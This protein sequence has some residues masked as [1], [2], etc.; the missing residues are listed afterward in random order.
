M[1]KQTGEGKYRSDNIHELAMKTLIN[2]CKHSAEA[3]LDVNLRELLQH[4][5]A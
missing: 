1:L 5:A 3:M 2:L 4:I